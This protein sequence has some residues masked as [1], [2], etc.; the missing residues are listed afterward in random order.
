MARS[1]LLL[2]FILFRCATL[3]AQ[4]DSTNIPNSENGSSLSPHGTIR[5]LVLYCEID[6]DKNPGKDPQPGSADHWTKGQLPAWKDDLFDPQPKPLPTAT[7][8]RY[9][10]DISLGD[11]VVL[12]DYIDQELVLKESEY[13]EVSS[14]HSI[15]VAAVKEANKMGALRTH[16]G[17]K[18][19]DFDLWTD[20][21]K[22]GLP[23]VNQPD[24]P[25]RYDHVMVIARNSGLTHGQG[26]TDPGSPG[27]LFGYESD[28]QSRFGGMNAL[29]FEILKHEFNH[30]L[31]GGN[32]FHSGGGNAAQFDSYTL[33]I[34]GGWSMMG[35][36]SSS[37][38][39]C[40]G[41]DRDRL[42]WKPS[43]APHRINAHDQSEQYVN[44][45][46][47]PIA[48]DT[49]LFILKD[50]V[51]S[52]DALRIRMPFLKE[53]SYPQWLWVEN[54]QTYSHN[55]SPT[56]RFHWEGTNN[57]CI[58]PAL[59]GLYMVMQ[60]D[61]ETKRGKDIYGGNADYLHVLTASGHFDLQ[62]TGD[63]IHD[64]CPFGG[65]ANAYR[66]VSSNPLTGNSEQELIAYDRNGDGTVERSEH[67]VPNVAMLP[68]GPS[69]NAR[70]FG[71]PEHAFTPGGNR[72][73][74]MSSNPSSAN[75]LTLTCNNKRELNKVSS[76][77]DRT[78]FL[79]GLRVELMEQRAN[80]DVVVK[81]A[82]GDTRI[83][84]DVRWCADSIVLPPLNGATVASLTIAS[85]KRLL[86]DRS[87]T[88]TRMT[89]QEEVHG[90]RYF[91][92][93]TRFTIASGATLSLEANSTLQLDHG[94]VIH[95][96][97]GARL[98]SDNK[99]SIVIDNGSSIILHGNA[100]MQARARTLKKLRKKGRIQTV[101]Q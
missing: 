90:Q 72:V 8:T 7:I 49:G 28:T 83:M 75:M 20:G 81:V 42:G 36:A 79:N 56:D 86:L 34:Q 97:P 2:A 68:S 59:P 66:R 11:F 63:T 41:W 52:G 98:I 99:A 31:L 91:A 32:N 89:L 93:P 57:P 22:P 85:R 47:D 33:C 9:Y 21:G 38:L 55:G 76:A 45:D 50:F 73:L 1:S 29:P 30:L 17:L 92:P 65:Q 4:P 44:G 40:S 53:G 46:L 51:T 84:Q 48:G 74:N 88:P 39:T 62:L 101:P 24:N 60:I 15:G 67:F 12:G 27:K 100:E 3:H 61:R 77:D 6:Y 95:I 13:P 69:N 23:K 96:M 71:R 64:K 16:H 70:F 94:S 43:G 37:L 54:H 87:A 19:E 10:H 35:A 82:T 14:A 18:L 25:H 78:V 26:S 80:G 58:S 5:V